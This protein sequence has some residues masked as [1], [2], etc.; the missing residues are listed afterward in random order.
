MTIVYWRMQHVYLTR[1][2]FTFNLYRNV[3]FHTSSTCTWT[4]TSVHMCTWVPSLHHAP[5]HA[6]NCTSLSMMRTSHSRPL[7]T[8]DQ[9]KSVTRNI[10]GCGSPY[11]VGEGDSWKSS[12]VFFDISV[13]LR[14]NGEWECDQT[15]D[16]M[17]VH[18]WMDQ[19]FAHILRGHRYMRKLSHA[20]TIWLQ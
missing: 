14:W 15:E 6:P 3:F 17:H 2:N 19:W 8:S 12:K 9:I 1:S 11:C 4:R 5:H 16:I 7:E 13:Q 18:C 20:L 10:G